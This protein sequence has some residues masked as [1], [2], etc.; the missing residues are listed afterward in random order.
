MVLYNPVVLM[1]FNHKLNRWH[2]I[3][4]CECPLP[5]GNYGD[6]LRWKSKGHHTEGFIDR[7]DA[8]NAAA[9]TCRQSYGMK[10][11]GEVYYDFESNI[12]WDGEGVP[13]MVMSFRLSDLTMY[14]PPKERC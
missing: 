5:S 7:Q 4:F 13:S 11:G 2:P 9:E 6:A 14:L 8:I 3:L 10:V 1:I 12:P